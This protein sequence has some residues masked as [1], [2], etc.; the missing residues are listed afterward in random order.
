M[1][2]RIVT[3]QGN[4]LHLTGSEVKV[5]E[6]A[7]EFELAGNDL[8]PVKLSSLRGQT[9]VLVT[10]PSLD[11]PVCDLE[12]RTFNKKAAELDP[13]VRILV[14]SMDLPF[15]QAR[16]CGASGVNKVTTLS[17]YRGAKLGMAYGVLIEELHLLARTIFVIDR[18]GK[19]QYRQIVG[20]VTNEPDYQ[21]AI[22]A[23]KKVVH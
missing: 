18:N 1:N 9:V 16:W 22:D 21:A 14:V 10:V 8:K 23:V 19:V 12:G 20:E 7:P 5:G 6:M 3:F 4:P 17:D 15:A 2:E 11:T 13:S